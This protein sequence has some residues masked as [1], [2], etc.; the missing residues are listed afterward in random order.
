MLFT[1]KGVKIL[2]LL[3]TQRV[4]KISYLLF[5]QRVVKILYLLFTQRV[6][7]IFYLLFT[8]RVVK[9]SYLLFT[10]RVVKISYL[11]F[12]LLLFPILY[13]QPN[14]FFLSNLG[15]A[16]ELA[17]FTITNHIF[18]LTTNWYNGMSGW[19]ILLLIIQAAALAC[20]ARLTNASRSLETP[21]E[22][23]TCVM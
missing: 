17:Y 23:L 7:K 16:I 22:C 18:S 1:Q 11:L 10:Q 15:L 21:F 3:F 12:S 2:Y 6:V 14:H 13:K 20:A 5:T 9:I 19:N 4:V 8:Q